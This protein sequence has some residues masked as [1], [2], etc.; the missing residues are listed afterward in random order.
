MRLAIPESSQARSN[1]PVLGEIP[2]DLPSQEVS[3]LERWVL[4]LVAERERSQCQ[5]LD[6][7]RPDSLVFVHRHQLA[8]ARG[9]PANV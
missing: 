3:G 1:R 9:A 4:R 6:A 2:I 7:S 8:V 5:V